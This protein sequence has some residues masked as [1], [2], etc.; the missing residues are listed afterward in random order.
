MDTQD[1]GTASGLAAPEPAH[2]DVVDLALL[3]TAAANAVVTPTSEETPDGANVGGPVQTKTQSAIFEHLAD[4]GKR[5][6]TL[7]AHLALRGYSLHRTAADDGPVCFYVTRWDMARELRDLA[8]VA[9]FLDQVGG[10]HA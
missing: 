2:H 3:G 4:D 9:R 10:A 8:A 7:R 6:T 5:F 1:H